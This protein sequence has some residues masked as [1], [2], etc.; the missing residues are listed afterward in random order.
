MQWAESSRT[1]E[2]LWRSGSGGFPPARGMAVVYIS[3]DTAAEWAI[4]GVPNDIM[5][6]KPFA[7]AEMITAVDQLLNDRST[8][9]A[10]A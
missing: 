10:S 8:G 1:L 9:P 3:G 7:M 5:L 2:S 4:N 6:E